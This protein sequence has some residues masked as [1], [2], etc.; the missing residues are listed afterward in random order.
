M[1]KHELNGHAPLFILQQYMLT[2]NMHVCSLSSIENLFK[3]KLFKMNQYREKAN[4]PQPKSKK[5][6]ELTSSTTYLESLQVNGHTRKHFSSHRP[7]PGFTAKLHLDPREIKAGQIVFTNIL[8]NSK[9]R[10]K[11]QY[12]CTVSFILIDLILISAWK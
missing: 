1:R 12:N 11:Y 4:F 8:L 2:G 3:K 6:M 7:E 9:F 5:K 10:K